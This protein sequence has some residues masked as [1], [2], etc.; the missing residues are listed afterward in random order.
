[1]IPA[2]LKIPD[3]R[4]FWLSRLATTIAQ[5]AMVI[6]IGWQVYD[7]ARETMGIREAA[8]QLGLVGLVQFVPLFVLTP[9]SGWTADRLDRRIIARARWRRVL[10]ASSPR[11]SPSPVSNVL[12][13]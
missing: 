9:V 4:A 11:P 12:S 10:T 7:V 8:F 5:M 13:P 2:P 6:V 3:Y 1:M